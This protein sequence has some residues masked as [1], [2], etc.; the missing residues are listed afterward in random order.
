MNVIMMIFNLG[1]LQ[2][3]VLNPY[4]I[5]YEMIIVMVMERVK[6]TERVRVLVDGLLFI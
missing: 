5:V 3:N 4:R 6:R 2:V 1:V